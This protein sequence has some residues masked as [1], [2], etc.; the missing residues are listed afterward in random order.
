MPW[1]RVDD[2]M[3][4]H[5]KILMAGNEA[6]GAWARMIAHCCAQLTDGKVTRA[7]A[8]SITTPVVIKHLVKC[9]MLDRDGADYAVHDF[10]DWNPPAEIVRA[11]REKDKSRKAAGRARQGRSKTGRFS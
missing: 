4:F 8:L 2:Q 7:V 10:H 11:K 9:R 5:P 1:A 3:A 6:V